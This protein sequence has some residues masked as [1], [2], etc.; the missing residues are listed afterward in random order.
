M[1]K[2][3]RMASRW[4]GTPRG[5]PM[6]GSHCKYQN[7]RR[8]LRSFRHVDLVSRAAYRGDMHAACS[9]WPSLVSGLSSASLRRS[10]A[11]VGVA[12]SILKAALFVLVASTGE[13]VAARRTGRGATS[14]RLSSV[15]LKLMS[16]RAR[17]ERYL[18][19]TCWV[20]NGGSGLGEREAQPH[21]TW[22]RSFDRC[23]LHC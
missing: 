11:S 21:V 2:E 15:A 1:G 3:T 9:G 4:T 8:A 13:K 20:G 16:E 19:V 22:S 14:T 23:M 18:R 12:E 10:R 5:P 7:R 6:A 17:D